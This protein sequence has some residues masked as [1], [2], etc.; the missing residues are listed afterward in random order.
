MVCRSKP[1]SYFDN[2]N[3]QAVHCDEDCAFGV[4]SCPAQSVDDVNQVAH[5]KKGTVISAKILDVPIKLLVDS[6][7]STNILDSKDFNKL[8][9]KHPHINLT[10]SK[11]R[12]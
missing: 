11:L 8:K 10:P 5:Q 9:A 7:A 4:Y 12:L 3:V 2:A 6:G 1:R